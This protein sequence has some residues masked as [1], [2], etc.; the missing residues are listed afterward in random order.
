MYVLPHKKPKCQFIITS[1]T[2][3]NHNPV[4]YTHPAKDLHLQLVLA[5]GRSKTRRVDFSDRA[6]LRH[7]Q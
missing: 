1:K 2:D 4:L 6:A 5:S 7:A 3:D